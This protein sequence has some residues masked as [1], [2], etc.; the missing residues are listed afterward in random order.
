M[1]N[2]IC[3]CLQKC[4]FDAIMI[5]NLPKNLEKETTHRYGPN[6]F[7]LHRLPVPR[8][9]QVRAAVRGWLVLWQ[10]A[11]QSAARSSLIIASAQADYTYSSITGGGPHT[12]WHCR[13]TGRACLCSAVQL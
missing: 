3:P 7:K 10:C 4:P 12:G 2:T 8:P 11:M 9:G 6:A 5:I 1:T 13:H